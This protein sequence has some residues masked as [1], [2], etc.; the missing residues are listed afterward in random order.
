MEKIVRITTI[1]LSLEKL[2]EGQLTFMN[3]HFEVIA[4]SAE[5]DRLEKYG[6]DNGVRTFPVDL[7]R[8]ITPFQDLKS[9]QDWSL[10]VI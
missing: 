1:P 5:K 8:A 10:R 6:H 3:N 7:T 2:L 9:L 4:V